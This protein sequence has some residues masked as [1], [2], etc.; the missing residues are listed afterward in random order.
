TP[1]LHDALPFASCPPDPPCPAARRR[2]DMPAS[3]SR[4]IAA[5]ALRGT[6]MRRL[7]RN[8]A[9]LIL[10]LL[11]FLLVFYLLPVALMLGRSAGKEADFAPYLAVFTSE[12]AIKVFLYTLRVAVFSTLITLLLAYPLAYYIATTTERRAMIL[13]AV[14]LVPFWT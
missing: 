11:G 9:G 12:V 14:V 6:A 10:P 7:L 3:P 13:L 5:P 2:H 4:R 8:P 1:P